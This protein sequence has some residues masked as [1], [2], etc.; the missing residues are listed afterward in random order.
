MISITVRNEKNMYNAYHMTKAFYPTED[1]TQKVDWKASHYVEISFGDK[2]SLI[3]DEEN[4]SKLDILIY[5]KLRDKTNKELAWGLLLGIRP[6][7]LVRKMIEDG[8]SYDNIKSVFMKDKFV[9]KEKTELALQVMEQERKILNQLN[10]SNGYSLYIGI[11]FCKSICSYC[12]FSSGLYETYKDRIDDYLN[13]LFRE[14]KSAITSME[15]KVLDTI[16]IGGGTPTSLTSIQLGRL[17]D[18]IDNTVDKTNLLEYTIEAGRPDTIDEEKL[19][20]IKEHGVT[21][22]S[23]NP[24]TM[25]QKTLDTIGRKHSVEDVINVYNMAR[26]VGFDNINMDII[27]GL[28]GESE[29]DVEDTLYKIEQ[30]GP[31]SLTVH[32][33]ALKRAAKL[34]KV[35]VD[36][37]SLEKMIEI[38]ASSAKNMNMKPYYL[39]RQKN[40]AGNFENIGYSKV[41][42]AGIYNILIM[43]ELQTII[44]CG[45]GATTK[46]VLQDKVNNNGKMSNIIRKDNVKS[47]EEYIRRH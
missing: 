45:A 18:Y 11:P 32:T 44:A 5:K 20:I 6:T 37:Q 19:K 29:K 33:L 42:K 1:I 31:D 14:I 43:E 35:K 3:M 17:L 24:Q 7:K 16:Y 8:K 41:D 9:S 23:I 15:G 46:I 40:I 22:I 30:L 27:L 2:T 38:S 28:E 26:R 34:E 25:Q 47:I 10:Y 12:S 13:S 36:A 4:K 21:R 39:Y